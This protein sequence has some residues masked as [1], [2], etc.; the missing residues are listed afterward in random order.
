MSEINKTVTEDF[1]NM[2]SMLSAIEINLL[3][4]DSLKQ[5]QFYQPLLYMITEALLD[6][7]NNNDTYLF[8]NKQP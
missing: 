6:S 1:N 7:K 3:G 5:K 8:P 4:V 2:R